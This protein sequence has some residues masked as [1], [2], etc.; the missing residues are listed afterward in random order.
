MNRRT[1]PAKPVPKGAAPEA[2]SRPFRALKGRVIETAPP[3]S[4]ASSPPVDPTDALPFD[5]HMRGVRPL[6]GRARRIPTSQQALEA[7]ATPRDPT[8]DLDEPARA[9]LH[10]LVSEGLAFEVVDDG[11]LLEGRR[12][13]VD[14]RELRRLATGR[15]PTDASLDLH[16][17]GLSDAR[18]AVT[19]FLSQ[20]R[21][22]GDRAVLIIHGRGRH[23]PRG[24]AVLRG[25]LGAWLSQGS[26][27]VHVAAFTSTR[28]S[29]GR[30]GAVMVLL[31]KR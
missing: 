9:R 27:A 18:K 16:G 30:S 11:V 7:P 21:S 29:D 3:S 12:L 19:S 13:S 2:V 1:K 23:S 28:E 4:R 26:A 6:P 17:L 24:E 5:V 31:A 14:P 25:E 15:Y 20:S 10:A 22:K 8:V